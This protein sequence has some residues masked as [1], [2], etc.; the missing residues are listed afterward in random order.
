MKPATTYTLPSTFRT[1]RYLGKGIKYINVEWY[2][3]FQGPG[4]PRSLSPSMFLLP[5]HP[6][7]RPRDV[8]IRT[9]RPVSQKSHASWLVLGRLPAIVCSCFSSL[10]NLE[11]FDICRLLMRYI[12]LTSRKEHLKKCINIKFV[13]L[14]VLAALYRTYNSCY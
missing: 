10:N 3:Y 12:S 1:E 7:I 13:I 9:F 6:Y 14:M 11:D 4:V 8:E 2:V 5:E